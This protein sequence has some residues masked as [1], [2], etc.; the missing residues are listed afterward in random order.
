MNNFVN[1][2]P[3][4]RAMI[5]PL[6]ACNAKCQ[7]C[8]YKHGDM[9][10]IRS[11]EA[12]KKDIDN[13]IARGNNYIDVSGGEPTIYPQIT[14]L[15]KYALDKNIK[16]CII[17][18]A[19]TPLNKLD[20]I[21]NAGID[22]FLVSIHGME[23]TH[24]FLVGVENAREKQISFLNHIKDKVSLRFNCVINQYNQNEIYDIAQWMIQWK[25]KIVNFINM[26][27]H[28]EWGAKLDETKKVIADLHIVEPLLNK[29]IE[30]LESNNIGVNVRYYPMCRIE[31]KYRR[32]ISNDLHVTF[33][34]YEWDYN[35]QPKIFETFFNW[36]KQT[37]I[38]IENKGFPCNQ[39][40]LQWICGGINKA[41]NIVSEGKIIS[42]V[43]G[44]TGD[45]NDFYYYRKYNIL[46]LR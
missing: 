1:P 40:D 43:K 45:K 14:D 15:I 29:A 28:G 39:C 34:P 11:F 22:E 6:R 36:G 30:L 9:K 23:K 12:V 46:T 5:D 17:T 2:E 13:A 24:N 41:F 33:D 26:N 32:C 27:P 44:F 3:T 37:S 31:E 18:N 25:P 7:F 35:I 10:S 20:E 38:N 8:Y 19:L 42:Q 21:I 16:T 4:K